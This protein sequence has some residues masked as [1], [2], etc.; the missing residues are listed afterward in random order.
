MSTNWF[1]KKNKGGILASE[2]W[3]R[4]DALRTRQRSSNLRD[5][6]HE[7]IYRGRPLGSG[8][9]DTITRPEM[10]LRS[11]PATVNIVKAKVNAISS[12]N[13][14]H[15]PFPVISAE[16][17]GWTEKRFAKR[18]SSVLRTRLGA[19]SLERDR[20]LRGRDA[21]VR[22]TGVAKVVRTEDGDVG[23]ER[24]PRSEILVS[25][26]EARYGCPRSMFHLKSYP[27]EVVLA[28]YG[29]TAKDRAAIEASASRASR[30]D[31]GYYMWGDDWADDSMQ[32]ALVEA[33]H[34][35]S[36]YGATDGRRTIS[37][38]GYTIVDEPWT[39]PRFPVALLHWDP[40]IRGLWGSG[41]VEDLAGVQAKMNDVHR[42]IQEALYY[43]AQLKVFIQRGA[44][45][46]K[47]HL[48]A[49][50][51]A[52]IEYD[53][54]A[55]QY[56]APT[57]VSQQLFSY[58]DWLLNIAD[59]ISG[60]SRDF[61]S[62]KT[63][64]GAGASGKA[65]DTLDDI[66]SDRFAMYQL[67]DSLHS[68]DVGTLV[69]DEAR[70]IAAELPKNEQASWIREHKWNKVEID[71]G[72]YHLKMEPM[73]FLPGTRAGKLEAVGELAAAGLLGDKTDALDMF[74]EP[75]MQS[76]NRK[77]LGPRRAVLRVV[78][79]LADEDI[80]LYEL[81]PDASFPLDEGIATV[82]AERE[83]AWATKAPRI[84]IERHNKWLQM[85]DRQ[86]TRAAQG[87]PPPAPAGPGMA[88]PG[89]PPMLPPGDPAMAPPPMAMPGMPI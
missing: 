1:D 3:K 20:V 50:H 45:V 34:L 38:R 13:S 71:G 51:P 67:F 64:L 23:V 14:K 8:G 37:G 33:W 57:P 76:M 73:N 42:D 28:R 48:R 11:A 40:P 68:V 27:L 79:G 61:Q 41:L 65:M 7:A 52:I 15:R 24:I 63:Q 26:R 44:N 36:G 5:L 62:G 10:A 72:G 12:R 59:D 18:V 88:P 85:A 39:R 19:T 55:P 80:D 78:E 87:A 25:A 77:L 66:Q 22:G 54:A 58:L 43:G 29:D 60:L 49:R 81:A 21:L 84:I 9:S 6:I 83:D 53:G 89:A 35:P 74:D 56:V 75:D 4:V 86:K 2:V 16:D 70:A 31:D 30:D 82:T 17:A 46:N 32:V 47:E 69:V